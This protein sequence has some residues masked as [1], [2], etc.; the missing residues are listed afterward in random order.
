MYHVSAQGVDERMINVHYYYCYTS[1]ALQRQRK[2]L[3][4]SF[5]LQ[6][7]IKLLNSFT[8]QR[9][10]KLYFFLFT[11]AKKVIRLSLYKGKESYTSF[12]LQR[13]KKLY[14]FCFTE[15]K[16]VRASLS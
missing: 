7:Q 16:K 5:A 11:K 13:Q 4:T 1:L 9:Q 15:T 8:L 3:Y 6:R 10:R 12:S 2:S 14:F